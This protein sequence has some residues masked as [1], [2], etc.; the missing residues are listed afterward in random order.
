MNFYLTSCVTLFIFLLPLTTARIPRKCMFS[1]S[2]K[3]P[4]MNCEET[5][6]Y[7]PFPQMSQLKELRIFTME[8]VTRIHKHNFDGFH[9]LE[10]LLLYKVHI[11]LEENNFDLLNG[12][13]IQLSLV[14]NGISLSTM[15]DQ[16]FCHLLQLNKLSLSSNKLNDIERIGFRQCS[17]NILKLDLSGNEITSLGGPLSLCKQLKN[18]NQLILSKNGI[19]FIDDLAL[20]KCSKLKHLDLGKNKLM[21]IS[22]SVFSSISGVNNVNIE[23]N[24]NLNF[25]QSLLSFVPDINTLDL[26]YIGQINFTNLTFTS[27]ANLKQMSL[28]GNSLTDMNYEAFLPL[29]GD[30]YKSLKCDNN[31]SKGLKFLLIDNNN[32]PEVPIVINKLINL[33]FLSMANNSIRIL[34]NDDVHNL[35]FLLNLNVSK[36]ELM[37]IGGDVFQNLKCLEVI[38]LS[39][40]MLETIETGAFDFNPNLKQILLHRN[41][42]IAIDSLFE[43]NDYALEYLD[44]SFNN[45]TSVSINKLPLSLVNINFSYN[46]IHHLNQT[47]AKHVKMQVLDL[48]FNR[49]TLVY[50]G[51]LPISLTKLFLNNNRLTHLNNCTFCSLGVIEE[52]TF[53]NNSLETIHAKWLDTSNNNTLISITLMGNPLQCDCYIP[54]LNTF[55]NRPT[56]PNILDYKSLMCTPVYNPNQKSAQT[57]RHVNKKGDVS[58][59]DFA[60]T[61]VRNLSTLLLSHNLISQITSYTFYNMTSLAFIYLRYNRLSFI[62]ENAF[63]N[64]KKLLELDLANNRLVTFEVWKF[65]SLPLL[66]HVSL[67]A[68]PWSCECDFMVE[69]RSTLLEIPKQF[70][71][72]DQIYCQSPSTNLSIPMLNFNMTDCFVKP[73]FVQSKYFTLLLVLLAVT[74]IFVTATV[75]IYFYRREVQVLIYSRYGVRFFGSKI[76]ED[77]DELMF[78]A[79]VSYS[80]DDDEFL[81]QEL[82]PK[83][84][85]VERH[86]NLCIHQRNFIA[87]ATIEESIM[88]AVANSRRTIVLLSSNFIKSKWCNYEF[89]M[90][91]VKMLQDRCNRLIVIVIGDIPQELEPEMKLYMK[92]NTYLKWGDKLFW[93]KLYFALPEISNTQPKLAEDVISH[94]NY[95]PLL[96]NEYLQMIDNTII[97]NQQ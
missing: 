11:E 92:T 28:L 96:S 18:L 8:N 61:S 33:Q 17:L 20:V 68:N 52:V 74:V 85:S 75:T 31:K 55:L 7:E 71:S 54:Q 50:D 21:T 14:N 67:K 94:S 59:D 69:F 77:D 19:E 56:F 82:L 63:D 97:E 79:F 91:H 34:E 32:L 23:H 26:S 43:Q 53:H 62:A 41:R 84:E 87:G 80:S 47:I 60:L 73:T 78:D 15:P 89:K 30:F 72:I 29:A 48:S 36:N 64:L 25:D 42:L 10:F 76:S 2:V 37:T 4:S 9:Q 1:F 24:E 35:T 6:P 58:I 49:L 51:Q 39:Y 44:V 93:Q 66:L 90:A 22:S 57:Q 65:K 86:Y 95:A 5:F 81:K 12:S 70:K 16:L 3:T 27:N 83:L 45:L 46:A 88:S 13:L 38:D 40:N